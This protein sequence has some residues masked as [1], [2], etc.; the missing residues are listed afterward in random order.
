MFATIKISIAYSVFYV[1]VLL[2]CSWVSSA[3]RLLEPKSEHCDLRSSQKNAGKTHRNV[4]TNIHSKGSFEGWGRFQLL[5]RMKP[6]SESDCFQ[7]VLIVFIELL[8]NTHYLLSISNYPL[9]LDGLQM[10]GLDA[11]INCITLMHPLTTLSSALIEYHPII[12]MTVIT[13]LPL[14]PPY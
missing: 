11:T 9:C 4:L 8:P 14:A 6:C 5:F 1:Y 10:C 3:S 12:F 13:T 7:R 2:K